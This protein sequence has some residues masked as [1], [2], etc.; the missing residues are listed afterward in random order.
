MD[1]ITHHYSTS[2][3]SDNKYNQLFWNPIISWKNKWKHGNKEFGE[4]FWGSSRWFVFLTDAWHLAQFF[5]I[6]FFSLAVI[7]F[8]YLGHVEWTNWVVVNWLIELSIIKFTFSG[9][10]SVFYDR[11]LRKR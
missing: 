2:I 8:G 1:K 10:F 5:M 11:F 9:G 6:T 7:S 3:F 4:K